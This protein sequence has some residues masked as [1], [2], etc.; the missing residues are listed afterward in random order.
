MQDESTTFN[1]WKSIWL[2]SR[3][4]IRHIIETDP[5]R[6]L[7]LLIVF[8]GLANA[9]NYAANFG[10]GDMMS[11]NQVLA[12]C[13]IAGPLSGFINVY[14]WSWLLGIS[15]KLFGGA[16]TQRDMRRAVAWSWAPLVYLLPLWGV[17]YILFRQEIFKSERPFIEAHSFL[18]SLHGLFDTVDFFIALLTIFI[19]F[20]TVAEVNGFSIWKSVG[21]I[22]VV[23]LI[24]TL[25]ALLLM[26]FFAPL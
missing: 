4:T 23:L 16:A 12:L 3:A 6:S 9:L 21:T 7:V 26:R 19:L 15:A 14:I 11:F 1:P 24:L 25:P 8:G 22:G 5:N 20:N 17:K 13:L 18:R 10:L 2:D